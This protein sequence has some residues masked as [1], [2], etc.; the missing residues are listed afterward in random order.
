VSTERLT[1]ILFTALQYPVPIVAFRSGISDHCAVY[2]ARYRSQHRLLLHSSLVLSIFF[3][4]SFTLR[5]TA[6]ASRPSSSPP[7][8]NRDQGT[9]TTLASLF[10]DDVPNDVLRA[11]TGLSDNDISMIR[12]KVRE[13]TQYSTVLCIVFT[14][15]LKR[16][17][18]FIAHMVLASLIIAPCTVCCDVALSTPH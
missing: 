1:E 3:Q 8:P 4:A 14:P 15:I 6:A 11:T 9:Q 17:L 16:V 7:S 12:E 18:C 2:S 13:E 10:K 5:S